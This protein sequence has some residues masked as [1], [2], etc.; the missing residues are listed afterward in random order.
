MDLDQIGFHRP[1]PAD[2]PGNHRLKAANLAAVW[3]T[4]RADGAGCLIV[5]G[6]LDQPEDMAVYTAA[7]PA[8][9]ITLC[10]LHASREV[11]ADRVARRG[12]GFTPAP[13]L[14]GDELIGQPATRLHEIADQAARNLDA[15]DGLGDL[16]TDTDNRPAEE[17]AA[18]ILKRTGWP[19]PLQ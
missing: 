2:D 14:A 10:L 18:E 11:L 5:V 1:V 16:R 15:L 9:T 4:F 7:L 3:R 19:S 13:G 6:P 17:I 8:A 12:Q